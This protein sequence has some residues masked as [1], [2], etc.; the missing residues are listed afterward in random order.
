MG[1]TTKSKSE[2][3]IEESINRF[4]N[5]KVVTEIIKDKKLNDHNKQE[6]E[7]F[8]NVFHYS[9]CYDQICKNLSYFIKYDLDDF[10]NRLNKLRTLNKN[11][12]AWY[13]T[14]MGEIGEEIFNLK[15]INNL[16]MQQKI[17]GFGTS[18][19]AIE[20]FKHVDEI[21][22][23]HNIECRPIYYNGND[24]SSEFRIRDN[25]N[26][27]FCYDYTIKE[28]NLI[29]EYHGEHCHPNKNMSA[30]HWANWRHAF[31]KESADIVFNKDLHK[32][33]LA[34]NNGFNYVLIWHSDS[35]KE[36]LQKIKCIITDSHYDG[37]LRKTKLNFII[38]TPDNIEVKGKLLDLRNTY[39]ISEYKARL[40]LNNK[41]E[42]YN[43]FKIRKI[44]EPI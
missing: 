11:S 6:L 36:N 16:H 9:K 4:L 42:S 13:I 19:S 26:K 3:T 28:L 22:K 41:L 23:E 8:F 32:Q 27:W 37:D 21:L 7:K 24:K 14:Q 5:L 34:T 43:G 20:F 12:K 31:T 15:Y 18:K 44:Y 33:E 29:I 25:N 38:T 40:M 1:K 30:A 10:Y 2:Y 39:N 35:K 17:P